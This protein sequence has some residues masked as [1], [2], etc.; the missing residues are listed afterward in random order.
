MKKKWML[1]P[2]I[3]LVMLIGCPSDPEGPPRRLGDTD[4]AIDEFGIYWHTFD[5]SDKGFVKFDAKNIYEVSLIVEDI[6]FSLAGCHF[7]G[8]LYYELDGQLYLIAGSQNAQPKN[9]ADKFDPDLVI[10]Y[11]FT[12]ELG[13]Y[14]TPDDG[15]LDEDHADKQAEGDYLIPPNLIIPAGA[16]QKFKLIVKTPNW[17]KMGIPYEDQ[18]P[19]P[20]NDKDNWDINYYDGEQVKGLG[21]VGEIKMRIKPNY[22]YVPGYIIKGDNLDNDG[23]G[24]IDGEDYQELLAAL[25]VSPSSILRV[26]CTANV[27]LSGGGGNNAQPGWG[28]AEFGHSTTYTINGNNISIA[29]DIPRYWEGQQVGVDPDFDFYADIL[30]ADIIAF[31]EGWHELTFLNV[32]NGAKVNALQIF[33]AE[34][35]EELPQELLELI[36]LYEELI[37]AGFDIQSL[38]ELLKQIRDFLNQ[39]P[40]P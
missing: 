24:N 18:E 37:A 26:W 12:F 17:Y 10:T 38:V 39:P 31:A 3:L 32:Y 8:Q 16:V 35:P 25:E 11:R 1:L 34:P 22:V 2:L 23:K 14:K 19:V 29:V 20:G 28:I 13:D 9:V 4:I 21:I 15:G 33:L 30:I 5:A 40:T 27:V 7:Q 36:D 6:D